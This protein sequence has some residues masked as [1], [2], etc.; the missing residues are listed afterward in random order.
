MYGL[1]AGAE[2]SGC[3]RKMAIVELEEIPVY[4]LAK[5]A[6]SIGNHMN[7]NAIKGLH[8]E[9]HLNIL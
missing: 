5:K 8:Y 7:A 9:W 3:C 1:S 2:K 4:M 6:V